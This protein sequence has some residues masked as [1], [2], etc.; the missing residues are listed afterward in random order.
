MQHMQQ[1]KYCFKGHFKAIQLLMGSR[2]VWSLASCGWSQASQKMLYL[3]T[4][5][6]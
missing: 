4:S 5:K 6:C 2:S 3:G 1:V